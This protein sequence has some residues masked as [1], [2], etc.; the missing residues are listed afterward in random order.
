MAYH[1]GEKLCENKRIGRQPQKTDEKDE[2]EESSI[3]LQGAPLAPQPAQQQLQLSQQSQLFQVPQQHQQM[4]QYYPPPYQYQPP[5]NYQRPAPPF[6]PYYDPFYEHYVTPV[7]QR[8]Y[9]PRPAIVSSPI[10]DPMDEQY[11][12][13]VEYMLSKTPGDEEDQ[14][15]V[16][17]GLNV[18]K[19][20]R[21]SLNTLLHEDWVLNLL[22]KDGLPLG[23]A[24]E[25]RDL[26]RGFKAQRKAHRDAV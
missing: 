25:I 3:P 6:T 12:G 22:N 17:Y 26:A 21:I 19:E 2:R 15:R 7:P 16:R 1:A 13:L 20:K 18:M 9:R 4:P 23:V 10:R 5:Q 24:Y 8:E 14:E 11:V